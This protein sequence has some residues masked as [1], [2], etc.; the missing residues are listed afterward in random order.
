MVDILPGEEPVRASLKPLSPH[1]IRRTAAVGASCGRLPWATTR[2]A[3]VLPTLASEVPLPNR[4]LQGWTSD[5]QRDQQQCEQPV[6][7][8]QKPAVV[9]RRVL[10]QATKAWEESGESPERCAALADEDKSEQLQSEEE[11]ASTKSSEEESAGACASKPAD[12][13]D[14]HFV[15]SA[16]PGEPI[17]FDERG[18]PI[19]L[20]SVDAQSGQTRHVV[21]NED[22]TLNTFGERTV[23]SLLTCTETDARLWIERL[24]QRDLRGLVHEL[25]Q[26]L[27]RSSQLY[28]QQQD[29]LENLSDVADYKLFGLSPKCTEREL[30]NAYRRM[31]KKMHPD[32]NGGTNFAKQRFQHMKERYESLKARRGSSQVEPEEKEQ[33]T[34]STTLVTFSL[35]WTTFTSVEAGKQLPDRASPSPTMAGLSLIHLIGDPWIRQCG[36]C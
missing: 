28:Q 29:I 4:L 15:P 17:A 9:I 20:R 18:Q 19:I 30:D 14:A 7:L 21:L 5:L 16:L 36:K 35:E 27:L 32:K 8:P 34:R 13:A 22:G 25:G 31:A 23:D 24:S 10:V 12:S 2:L 33:V 6:E 3:S 26:R 1:R 11:T